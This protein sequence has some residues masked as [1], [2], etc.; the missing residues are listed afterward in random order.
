MIIEVIDGT[1][2]SLDSV[3]CLLTFKKLET[4]MEE[5]DIT[6]DVDVVGSMLLSFYF[7]LRKFGISQ[8]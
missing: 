5:Y 6:S 4:C 7:I 3:R 1:H 2:H 8:G